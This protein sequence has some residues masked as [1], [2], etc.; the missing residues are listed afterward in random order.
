[1]SHRPPDGDP[2]DPRLRRIERSVEERLRRLAA[3]GGLSG[4][5][6]EGR[7]ID[8]GELDGDDER[9]AAFRL[10]K[11]NKVRP[12]WSDARAAIDA[13]RERLAR[14]VRAHRAWL[15]AR[16]ALLRTLPADRIVD[17]ARATSRE[18]ARV[19]AEVEAAVGELN[20]AVDRYNAIV[21]AESLRLSPISAGA[22]LDAVR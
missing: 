15:T 17:A 10:M 11:N 19:R 2:R 6:G 7:P 22:L 9:W 1:M 21:P 16:A 18:D 13:E 8:P 20:G 4:L 12:A 5:P 3:D 14:R